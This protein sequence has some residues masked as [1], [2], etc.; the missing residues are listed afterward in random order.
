MPLTPLPRKK[1]ELR[2]E[3]TLR[4]PGT[5]EYTQAN[6]HGL[7]PNS[8]QKKIERNIAQIRRKFVTLSNS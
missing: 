8:F 1:I 2:R 6:A 7:E 5:R 3:K 4:R